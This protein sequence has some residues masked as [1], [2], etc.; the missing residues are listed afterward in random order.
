MRSDCSSDLRN[1]AFLPAAVRRSRWVTPIMTASAASMRAD[2]DVLN[3]TDLTLGACSSSDCSAPSSCCSYLLSRRRRRRR[4]DGHARRATVAARRRPGPAADR[5][6]PRRRPHSRIG[7]RPSGRFSESGGRARSGPPATDRG[8]RSSI[9]SRLAAGSA[10]SRPTRNRGASIAC[11]A[12]MP[13]SMTFRM[14]S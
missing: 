7:P 1:R 6:R 5:R 13:P 11:W 2:G 8:M 4:R 14:M 12:S 9:C 10:G 3:S